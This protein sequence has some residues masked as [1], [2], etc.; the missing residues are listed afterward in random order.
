M[1]WT[2]PQSIDL[3]KV[4]AEALGS[5]SPPR[6]QFMRPDSY[7][8]PIL[9]ALNHCCEQFGARLVVRFFGHYKTEFDVEVLRQLP[10]VRNLWLDLHLVKN[11]EFVGQLEHLE[12]FI[13][14]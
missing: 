5:G 11:L 6:I 12:E 1:L 8:P 3:A 9:E 13:L 7:P 4:E 10:A 2:D 14:G